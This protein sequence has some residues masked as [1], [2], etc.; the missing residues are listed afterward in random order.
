MVRKLISLAAMVGV[1]RVTT[2]EPSVDNRFQRC[3]PAVHSQYAND[4]SKARD[5]TCVVWTW[6][7]PFCNLLC[8][9]SFFLM[10]LCPAFSARYWRGLCAWKLIFCVFTVVFFLLNSSSRRPEEYQTRTVFVNTARRWAIEINVVLEKQLDSLLN[11]H[12][13]CRNNPQRCLNT[14]TNSFWTLNKNEHDVF[15]SIHLA[16]GIIVGHFYC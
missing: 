1:F 3:C 9:L 16:Y 6:T 14:H 4:I 15:A 12:Q 11:V 7:L 10:N 2:R 8:Y 13:C 5:R